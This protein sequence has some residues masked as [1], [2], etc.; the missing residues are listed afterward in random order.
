VDLEVMTRLLQEA[1]WEVT[2]GDGE[3]LASRY[4]Q[5]GAWTLAIDGAGRFLFTA[6]QPLQPARSARIRWA[7]LACRTAWEEQGV[8]TLAT[9]V[10][11][12][13]ELQQVLD[14]LPALARQARATRG[15]PV[16]DQ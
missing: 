9:E 1:G 6:T 15:K 4:D 12:E 13:E 8:F 3:L 7:G 16:S 5:G 10:H 11:S 14:R 2:L